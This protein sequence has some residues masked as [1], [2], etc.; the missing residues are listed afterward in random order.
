MKRIIIYSIA[1]ISCVIVFCGSNRLMF[2]SNSKRYDIII[3]NNLKGVMLGL[4]YTVSD[5]NHYPEKLSDLVK[6]KVETQVRIKSWSIVLDLNSNYF[7]CPGTGSRAGCISNVDEWT[8]FIYMGNYADT[9]TD[10]PI[11]I[12]PP[13]NHH[14]HYG[15]VVMLGQGIM[16]LPADQVR[17]LIKKPWLLAT[18]E[19]ADGI[20]AI[21]RDV[22][23]NVPPRLRVY[24]TN[25]NNWIRPPVGRLQSQT[26]T[27]R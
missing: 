14:G 22:I 13:E 7:I 9:K 4:N 18:N 11:I 10:V 8:D 12:S 26:E 19:T 25:A 16:R 15:Y 17:A 1:F 21:K 5:D 27:N 20:E 23:V 2:G 6:Y 24:Y 3:T